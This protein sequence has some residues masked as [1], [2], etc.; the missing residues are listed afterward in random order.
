MAIC[1]WV[2]GISNGHATVLQLPTN[3][4]TVVGQFQNA[5]LSGAD[6]FV[7]V[8]RL[9]NVGFNELIAANPHVDPWLPGEGTQVVIP[10]QYILKIGLK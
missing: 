2:V 7:D 1:L 4:D 5:V 3:G 10:S 8:A 9:Y 6:T